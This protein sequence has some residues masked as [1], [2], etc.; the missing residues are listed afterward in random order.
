MAGC[1]DSFASCLSTSKLQSFTFLTCAGL[2]KS[3]FAS[4]VSPRP[5]SMLYYDAT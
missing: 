4:H 1:E 2:C 3:I 5:L